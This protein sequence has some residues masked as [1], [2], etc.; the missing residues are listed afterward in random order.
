MTERRLDFSLTVVGDGWVGV[1]LEQERGG[2]GSAGKGRGKK[3]GAAF[4]HQP[5]E[6]ERRSMTGKE[7]SV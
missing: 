1:R 3:S 2:S 5:L 4:Y 7:G 6:A